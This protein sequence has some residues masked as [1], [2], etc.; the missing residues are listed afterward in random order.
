MWPDCLCLHGHLLICDISHINFSHVLW[1]LV[2]CYLT[3][4]VMLLSLTTCWQLTMSPGRTCVIS[5]NNLCHIT[6]PLADNF[7]RVTWQFLS[8]TYVSMRLV[9]WQLFLCHL[10][11][12]SMS[13]EILWC[14]LLVMLPDTFWHAIWWLLS[15]YMA[16]CVMSPVSSVCGLS[17]NNLSHITCL[18][19]CYMTISVMSPVFALCVLSP[20]NLPHASYLVSCHQFPQYVSCH[21]TTSFMPPNLSHVT[22]KFVSCHQFSQY[23]SCHLTTS[24]MPPTWCRVTWQ[25]VMSPVASVCGLSPNNLSHAT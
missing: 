14:H 4:C 18:V 17:P 2:S 24:F 20:N 9:T 25:F 10:T 16:I 6:W 13:P 11:T 1:Q 7:H 23:V 19:S 15:Y 12:S 5:P 3:A 8:T 22:W 21:L